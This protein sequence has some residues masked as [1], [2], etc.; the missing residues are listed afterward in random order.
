[1]KIALRLGDF[2]EPVEIPEPAPYV[3]K[4][5]LAASDP[6]FE[7]AFSPDGSTLAACDDDQTIYLWPAHDP[8]LGARAIDHPSALASGMLGV[9]FYS[10]AFSPDSQTIAAGSQEEVYLYDLNDLEREPIILTPTDETDGGGEFQAVAYSP[11]GQYL[12][13]GAA[14][15]RILS[16][17]SRNRRSRP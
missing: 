12:A 5:K 8:E 3:A 15:G 13:G 9:D 7:V 10:L 17:R 11:D 16:G 6:V 14:D 4:V 2:D 1:M